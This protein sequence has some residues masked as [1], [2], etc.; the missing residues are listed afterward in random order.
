MGDQCQRRADKRRYCVRA[1]LV[2]LGLWACAGAAHAFDAGD[3]ETLLAS[4]KCPGCDLRGADLR[5]R[6]LNGVQLNAADLRDARLAGSSLAGASLRGA[7]LTG[8]DFFEVRLTGADLRDADLSHLHIDRDLEFMDLT[9]VLLE[10][11]RFS[12]GRRCGPLPEIGG[13]GCSTP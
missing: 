9:G 12:D 2:A 7:R 1:I 8:I 13:W 6:N 5:N 3:L 11:A 10:G 4:G